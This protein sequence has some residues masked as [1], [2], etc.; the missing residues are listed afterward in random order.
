MNEIIILEEDYAVS[1]FVPEH[2][3]IQVIW[4]GT[5]TKEQYQET[6]LKVLDFQGKCEQTITNF[7]SD[8]RKQGMVSPENRK[9][10]E[11]VVLPRGI[12]QGYKRGAVVFDGTIFKKYYLNIILQAVNKF[13]IPFKF[14]YTPEEVIE[15]F[16]SFND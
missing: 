7:M 8:I 2:K 14:F 10:F 3:M 6:F 12:A 15:W 1:K 5:L 11:T 16:S 9:W 13:K 4:N